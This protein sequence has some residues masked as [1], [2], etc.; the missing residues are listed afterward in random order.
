MWHNLE[1]IGPAQIVE[2][3]AA[4][5]LAGNRRAAKLPIAGLFA[6]QPR[7]LLVDD[8]DNVIIVQIGG[9]QH[10]NA[11]VA[12]RY[13]DSLPSR[14]ALDG[15]A[16]HL[17]AKVERVSQS[18][19]RANLARATSMTLAVADSIFPASVPRE[20]NRSLTGRGIGR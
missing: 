13:C 17:A 15:K 7:P 11:V 12:D 10:A 2:G 5:D 1:P 19:H 9:R 14:R 16:H 20:R 8:L 3:F 4:D 18:F 6:H